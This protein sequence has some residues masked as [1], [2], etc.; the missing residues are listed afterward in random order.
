MCPEQAHTSYSCVTETLC[1][2]LC[3]RAKW[4]VKKK[5]RMNV[6][7]YN[8][9]GGKNRGLFHILIPILEKISFNKN[10]RS[11]IELNLVI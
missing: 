5:D 1:A 6:R 4:A 3:T 7:F 8:H 10:Y 2:L 9:K 11:E